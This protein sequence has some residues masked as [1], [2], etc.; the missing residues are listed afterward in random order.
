MSKFKQKFDSNGVLRNVKEQ[1]IPQ[2]DTPTEV[3]RPGF[4]PE[5]RLVLCDIIPPTQ[6]KVDS[7]QLTSATGKVVENVD[8]VEV[9]KSGILL[10]T[11]TE[12][13]PAYRAIVNAVGVDVRG[14][15]IGDIISYKPIQ[16]AMMPMV[17]E[18]H[19]YWLMDQYN[20]LGKYE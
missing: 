6:K 8:I 14:Y 15:E 10:P 20:L 19:A 5:G 18:G 16:Q 17:I 3:R 9:T 2:F 11:G 4:K 12:N 7:V 13:D 1:E